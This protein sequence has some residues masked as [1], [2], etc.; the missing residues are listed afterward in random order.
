MYG[1]AEEF[2]LVRHT[3]YLWLKVEGHG[4]RYSSGEI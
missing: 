3:E 2:T 4:A 1:T